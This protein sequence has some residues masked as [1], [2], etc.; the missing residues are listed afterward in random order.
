[1]MASAQQ[2]DGVAAYIDAE[3]AM[4]P[5][6]AFKCGLDLDRLLVSQPDSAEQ[7]LEI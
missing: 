7:W 6:Y 5:R 3:H 1:M 2:Q 4:D